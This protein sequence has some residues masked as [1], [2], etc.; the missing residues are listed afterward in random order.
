MVVDGGLG[1][2]EWT[3][4]LLALIPSTLGIH[5]LGYPLN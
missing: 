5:P 1:F 4:I 2:A 3:F